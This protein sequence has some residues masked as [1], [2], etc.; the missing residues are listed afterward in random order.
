M[1]KMTKPNFCAEIGKAIRANRRMA[2][3]TQM[4]FSR[5]IGISQSTLSKIESGQFEPGLRS[6]LKACKRF[7][8]L[9]QLAK[10]LLR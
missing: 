6:F 9:D 3:L 8:K 4:A 7:P 10:S 2:D 1:S 5:E